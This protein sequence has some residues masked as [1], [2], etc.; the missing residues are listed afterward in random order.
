MKIYLAGSITKQS[1][2]QMKQQKNKYLLQTFYDMRSWKD[3]KIEEY[4]SSCEEFLLDSGA[5]TFMNSGKKVNWKKYTDSYIDFINKWNIKQFVEL[6]LDHVLGV[7]ETIKIRNYLEHK[8]QKQSIPVFH[9]IRGI[10][11]YRK[12]MCEEYRYI[13][14]AASGIVK[15]VDEYVKN[16]KTLR[17][18]LKIAHENNCYVH[19]LAYTR[20]GNIN[21]TTV[22]FDSVDS[23]AWLS[24]ARYGTWYKY[25]NGHLL[26]YNMSNK[27]ISG[28][29]YNK[30]NLECWIKIQRE[31]SKNDKEWI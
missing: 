25:K 8:T 9:A 5:F 3:E 27:G 28:D 10:E 29:V 11:Y 2:E 15:D 18:L 21:K 17:S 12:L 4:L 26:S 23:T 22:P 13:A 31:K 24:G 30:N 19:G 1:L 14:I 16:E 7:Q 6:D 20:L